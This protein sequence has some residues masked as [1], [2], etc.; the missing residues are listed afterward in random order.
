MRE[1]VVDLLPDDVGVDDANVQQGPEDV[2][3][4]SPVS[5]THT[6]VGPRLWQH[7]WPV[8]Y[9]I[10]S[11]RCIRL[12]TQY[13]IQHCVNIISITVRY[14]FNDSCRGS[15]QKYTQLTLSAS[16]GNGGHKS[17]IS[18]DAVL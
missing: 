13:T 17:V 5:T 12:T 9:I 1:V 16:D 7:E 18:Q 2:F 3:P 11:N 4:P 15:K 14:R 6:V 8:D 10:Y